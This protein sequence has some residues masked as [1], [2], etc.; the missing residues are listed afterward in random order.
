[1]T[2]FRSSFGEYRH[3]WLAALGLFFLY[4]AIMNGHLVSIDGLVMWRQALS[5]GYQ[6]SLQFS[7]PIWWA[8]GFINTSTRGIAAS[9]QYLPGL[10][11]SPLVHA[12]QPNGSAA[13]D[14]GL[15]YRDRL[16]VVAGAPVWI[17]VTAVAAFAVGLLT[18]TLGFDRSASLWAIAF[19]GIGSPALLGARGDFPQPLVALCWALGVLAAL[20]MRYGGS[21]RWMWLCAGAIAYGVL[22][23]P[24][25]GS[26]L[27]PAVLLLLFR[28]W[29]SGMWRLAIPVLAWVGAVAITLLVNQARFGSPMNFGYPPAAWTLPIWIGFPYAF[30]S[31][32]RGAFWQFPA[33]VLAVPGVAALWRKDK[34]VEALVFAVLPVVLFIE[35][36]TYYAWIDGWDWGFRLFQPALPLVAVLAGIGSV[37]LSLRLAR[38]LPAALLAAGVLWNIPAVVTDLLGGYGS[39][40]D[41][42]ASW[43]KLDAY[44]LIGAWQFLHHVRSTGADDSADID[45]IWFRLA[46]ITH[47]LSLIPFL[48]FLAAAAAFWA[49][50]L[51]LSRA[52]TPNKIRP[53]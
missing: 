40:Y 43:S 47:W 27:V 38:W 7:P 5:I 44:P 36:C 41:N 35:S 14:Y 48:A 34:R 52:G 53:R 24:L 8:G 10:V 9:I 33:M 18:R 25:E 28:D 42:L 20:R 32:G 31:P 15:F 21:R 30:L 1:M 46:R 37:Q 13:A 2:S 4:L 22:S 3:E 12:Y 17:V 49:G 6:H 51:R 45:I 39:T 50:A 11:L 19:Y 23:R 26:F 16:Y 29:R